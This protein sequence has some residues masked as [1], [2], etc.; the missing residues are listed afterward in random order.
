MPETQTPSTDL[1]LQLKSEDLTVDSATL[2]LVLPFDEGRTSIEAILSVPAG[3]GAAARE[4]HIAVTEM[5]TAARLIATDFNTQESLT[6]MSFLTWAAPE[7]GLHASGF[8]RLKPSP[9]SRAHG[10]WTKA[11]GD[12]LYRTLVRWS[13]ADFEYSL[14]RRFSFGARIGRTGSDWFGI[15]VDAYLSS[16]GVRRMQLRD[17]TGVKGV[18]TTLATTDAPWSFDA[19]HWLDVEV[20]GTSVKARIYP[21]AATV[22]PDWQLGA[23]T[24]QTAPGA[25]GPGGFPALDESP[26]I[27]LRRMEYFPA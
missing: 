13:G 3:E 26:V 16:T 5:S 10:A 22:V 21:E 20:V 8:A 1:K 7:W 25:V 23:T 6:E 18:T 14:D 9:A 2:A 24:T 15:R 19:W 11:A 27:D 17:Y 12:G 4:F